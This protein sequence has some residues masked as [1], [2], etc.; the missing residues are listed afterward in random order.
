MQAD[1]QSADR[2]QLRQLSP[3][4]LLTHRFAAG[5]LRR[6]G[7]KRRSTGRCTSKHRPTCTSYTDIR[8]GTVARLIRLKR[9]S[10]C[11]IVVTGGTEIG[12]AHGPLSH[13]N[14][15]KVD[16]ATNGC[17]DAYIKQNHR[18]IGTRSDGA[19]LYG[20]PDTGVIFARESDHWD[21]AFP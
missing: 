1:E 21:I 6:A 8:A 14:G 20:S 5:Q 16:I 17:I 18:R 2:P 3:H 4:I 7:I 9:R 15:Y 10:K 12:H 13:A 11:P 19:A